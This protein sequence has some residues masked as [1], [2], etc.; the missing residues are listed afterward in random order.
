MT[1]GT[2]CLN[3]PHPPAILLMRLTDRSPLRTLC[4]KRSTP[5]SLHPL[6][7]DEEPAEEM[8]VQQR[9]RGV[10][11]SGLAPMHRILQGITI[12]STVPCNSLGER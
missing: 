12:L 6:R 10:A 8:G 11:F 4:H 3:D 5:E 7:S 9:F 1:V 2:R